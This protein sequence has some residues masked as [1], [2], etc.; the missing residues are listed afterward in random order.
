MSHFKFIKNHQKKVA[1]L[2]FVTD[3]TIWILVEHIWD[4]FVHAKIRNFDYEE[5]EKAKKWILSDED[6]IIKHKF[7]VN[8]DSLKQSWYIEIK[9][10][11]TLTHDDYSKA[12]PILDSTL[13]KLNGKQWHILL[14]MTDFEGWEL[15]AAWDDFKFWLKHSFNLWK[16]AIV[17]NNK[18]W[19]EYTMKISSWFIRWEIKQFED[20]KEAVKW[21]EE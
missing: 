18:K 5:L 16:I 11:W 19:I 20:K 8:V 13:D 2:A 15:R 14:D 21:L 17:W 4:Y 6:W 3:A 12:I 1:Y 7:Y 10:I 9:I